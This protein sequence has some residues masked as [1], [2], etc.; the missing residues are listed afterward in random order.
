MIDLDDKGWGLNT[1]IIFV[2]VLIF[3]V[4]LVFILAYQIDKEGEVIPVFH[5]HK[6][7]IFYY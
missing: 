2:C 3:V 6:S 5:N 1:M 4:M 7:I